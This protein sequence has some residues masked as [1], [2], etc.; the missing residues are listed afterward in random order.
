MWEITINTEYLAYLKSGI[1]VENGKYFIISGCVDFTRKAIELFAFRTNDERLGKWTTND[2][3]KDALLVILHE[4][5]HEILIEFLGSK[6]VSADY[7]N[8]ALKLENWLFGKK[9]R[10]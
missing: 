4:N 3:V 5:I 8:I 10:D 9:E 7:D 6:F 1:V 2:I